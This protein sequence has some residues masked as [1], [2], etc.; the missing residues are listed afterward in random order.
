MSQL[1]PRVVLGLEESG[2]PTVMGENVEYNKGIKKVVDCLVGLMDVEVGQLQAI[3][4][5][6]EKALTD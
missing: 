4:D 3:L 6:K 2:R 1:H 5:F